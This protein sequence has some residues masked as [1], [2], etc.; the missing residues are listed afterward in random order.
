MHP[1][2][3]LRLKILNR[4]KSIPKEDFYSNGLKASTILH[5]SPLWQNYNTIFIFLSMN[6]EIDTGP[7]IELSFKD[8]KKAFAPGIE[9]DKNTGGEIAFYRILSPDGPWHTG[10]LG[11]REPEKKIKADSR[12]FP[13]LVLA[14]GLAFD[15]KGNR[16]GRGKGYYD[17]FFAD[18][19]AEGRQYTS[20]GFS[21][22]LQI[23]DFVYPDKN[24][25]KMNG[26]LTEKEL[27][28]L[29]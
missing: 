17:R 19:D 15:R 9:V 12:D 7:L 13:A 24:D 14:P 2:N 11:I 27:L 4:L 8:G 29:K 10:S 5:N 6:T 26:L 16:L 20:L 25:K 1:K 28:I 21:M 18:L 3:K 22:D 23:I